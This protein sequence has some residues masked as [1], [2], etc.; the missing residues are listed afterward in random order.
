MEDLG[1]AYVYDGSFEGFLSAVFLAYE[2]RECPA[3]VV[4]AEQYAPR[5]GQACVSVATDMGH[6]M[7][8]RA[9]IERTC[10]PETF[11]QVAEAY[12]SDEPDKGAAAL[13]FV[14][15]AMRRGPRA[16]F[17]KAA[18]EVAR[19]AEIVRGVYNEQHLWVQF[20]RFSKTEGGVYV[21]ACNPKA[22]V[23]PLLMG[24]FSL[25]FNVQ[26][27]VVYDE[28]H[29]VAGVSRDGRWNLV[30]TC[31]FTPPP[32]AAG[33][34]MYERAWKAF[35]DAISIDARYNPELRMRSMPKRLWKNVVELKDISQGEFGEKEER[36]PLPKQNSDALECGQSESIRVRAE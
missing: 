5:L 31:D 36:R 18:P 9:G 6:A 15:Y 13:R 3:D 16:R 17:D 24:W 29:H 11:R 26:P 27:F 34:E 8:V 23:V 12:L 35:Y 19:F 22:N 25:R 2:R 7:R 28:V 20:L 14:R 32:A 21:A 30:Q 1:L 33:D 10:G 4:G